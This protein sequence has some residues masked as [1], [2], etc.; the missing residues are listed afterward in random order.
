MM[1][2]VGVAAAALLENVMLVERECVALAPL[3]G[4]LEALTPRC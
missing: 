1:S 4:S 2:C 3:V